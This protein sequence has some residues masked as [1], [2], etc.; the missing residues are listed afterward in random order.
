MSIE[1]K[2][3]WR[4]S[5]VKFGMA[6]RFRFVIYRA[7]AVLAH[8]EDINQIER[9]NEILKGLKTWLPNGKPQLVHFPSKSKTYPSIKA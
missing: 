9:W 5:C 3:V 1:Y 8:S 4:E 2:S 6:V 7:E